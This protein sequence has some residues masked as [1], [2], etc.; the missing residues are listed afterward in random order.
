[1][2]KGH[3]AGCAVGITLALAFV[4]FTGG[5]AGGFGLLVASLV[6]PI[7]MVVAMKFLMG[8]HRAHD[9]SDL[10]SAPATPEASPA[11]PKGN[12]PVA[13]SDQVPLP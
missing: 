13:G 7:A 9:G 10:P 11:G 6:C 12:D 4:A 3:L 5:S 8:D 1:M 2:H